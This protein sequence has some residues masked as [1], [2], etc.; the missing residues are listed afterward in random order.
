MGSWK[1]MKLFSGCD[2]HITLHLL[3]L[4]VEEYPAKYLIRT[5]EKKAVI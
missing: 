4:C 5:T 2:K 3:T 1:A